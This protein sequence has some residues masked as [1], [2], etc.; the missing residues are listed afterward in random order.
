MLPYKFSYS[1]PESEC[2]VLAVVMSRWDDI[3]GPK[4]VRVWFQEV[5]GEPLAYPMEMPDF[6]KESNL[7]GT[8]DSAVP[9]EYRVSQSLGMGG[10]HFMGQASHFGGAGNIGNSSEYA[11]S[12]IFS[13]IKYVTNH[14]VNCLSVSADGNSA[15]NDYL[16]EKGTSFY[17]VPD[18]NLVFISLMF[19]VKEGRILVPYSIAII[20]SYDNYHYFLRLRGLCLL[21]LRRIAFRF[22]TLLTKNSSSF[23]SS[24]WNKV[25][26]WI[27]DF[28]NMLIEVNRTGLGTQTLTS[29]RA[30]DLKIMKRALTSHLQT[31]G[32]SVVIGKTAEDINDVLCFLG[33]FLN[34]A[35]RYSTCLMDPLRKY[36]Y[37]MGLKLQGLL[38]D[39]YG[40][41]D[42][43][44]LE[45]MS[46][47]MPV[48]VIDLTVGEAVGAVK[49]TS[50]FHSYLV[51]GQEMF[52]H[53]YR[54]LN[55]EN[56]SSEDHE[57]VMINVR[58]SG[59]L[60]SDA[61]KD[62]ELLPAEHWGVY[63]KTFLRKLNRLAMSLLSLIS[64]LRSTGNE[65]DLIQFPGE[66]RGGIT[67]E[68]YLKDTLRL[69]NADF[70]VVLSVA[71]N[72][73]PGTYIYVTERNN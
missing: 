1:L 72:L 35:D 60:V 41:R 24:L 22:N 45:L 4:T 66:S 6:S 52:R 33:L 48:T 5:V 32:S 28:C 17:V 2:G 31:F 44:S 25:N 49:Q 9:V 30:V 65:G 15:E 54:F 67:L 73:K 18:V 70:L 21:W 69:E 39:E 53:E 68:K 3:V 43:A 56:G 7:M 27:L 61:V 63:I 10:K 29:G 57:S 47:P 34:E 71:E 20:A 40:G 16:N 59:K 46:N 36:S 51:G 26:E 55:E 13:A 12:D 11:E 50:N 64:W 42:L 19:L 58:E 8:S 23:D 37:H 38:L 62:M 14:T